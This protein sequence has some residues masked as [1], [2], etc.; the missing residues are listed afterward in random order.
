MTVSR[1]ASSCGRAFTTTERLQP[2]TCAP[3]SGVATT[4]KRLATR[5][6][7]RTTNA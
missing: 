6:S 3:G 5:F 2:R 7:R 1:G 4:R